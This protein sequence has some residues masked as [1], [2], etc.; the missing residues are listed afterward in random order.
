MENW[1][2]GAITFP[3]PIPIEVTLGWFPDPQSS[4]KAAKKALLG[5]L[6][7]RRAYT[8]LALH[9]S[10]ARK[11]KTPYWNPCL[12]L[13][14]SSILSCLQTQGAIVLYM[15]PEYTALRIPLPCWGW[16]PGH[17]SSEAGPGT[18]IPA[19]PFPALYLPPQNHS[20]NVYC[21]EMK[22][23]LVHISRNWFYFTR[24]FNIPK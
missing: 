16:I 12:T 17:L 3:S 9:L 5:H 4:W 10:K 23:H 18:F 20:V 24:L 2:L 14:L 13:K 8:L 11:A 21:H 22:V 15:R 19:P 6:T 7:T 1:V